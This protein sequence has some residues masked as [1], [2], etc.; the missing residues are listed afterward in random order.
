MADTGAPLSLTYVEVGQSGK[1]ATFNTAMAGDGF[2]L[3]VAS[4][5]HATFEPATSLHEELYLATQRRRQSRLR[6]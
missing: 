6:P 2:S 3:G 1:E 5:K 4:Y